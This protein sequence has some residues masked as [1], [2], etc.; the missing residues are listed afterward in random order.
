MGIT[1][2]ETSGR[3]GAETAT[4]TGAEPRIIHLPEAAPE[5]PPPA[6]APAPPPAPGPQSVRRNRQAV[7]SLL[8]SVLWLGGVGSLAAII[9]GT[10]ARR[11]GATARGRGLALAG[12]LLGVVGLLAALGAGGW[13]ALMSSGLGPGSSGTAALG[14]AFTLTP[15]D[16]GLASVQVFAVDY[17]L[18]IG[19]GS[20]DAGHRYATADVRFCAN[21]QGT[22]VASRASQ[23][24]LAPAGSPV[25]FAP[26]VGVAAA[27]VPKATLGPGECTRGLLTFVIPAGPAGGTLAFNPTASRSYTWKVP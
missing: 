8:L 26:V 11:R 27:P 18:D 19:Q 15:P 6:S 16:R 7:A 10:R 9:L 13:I 25:L 5:T 3:Q 22:R 24:R 1:E 23:W 20:L 17:P 2:H 14:H 12:V 21:A 4:A